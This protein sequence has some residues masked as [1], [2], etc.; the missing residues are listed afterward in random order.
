MALAASVTLS[1]NVGRDSVAEIGEVIR[2]ISTL[3]I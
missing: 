2:D 1:H 3:G